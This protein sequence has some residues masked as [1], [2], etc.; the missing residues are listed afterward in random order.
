MH[1]ILLYVFVVIFIYIHYIFSPVND[2]RK[3][4]TVY[5]TTIPIH[6]INKS[7]SNKNKMNISFTE[8]PTITTSPSKRVRNPQRNA[9]QLLLLY[10]N[11][12]IHDNSTYK[13]P[14]VFL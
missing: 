7:T 11:Y 3:R 14:Y 4:G 13:Q 5:S 8:Y 1:D 6:V 12:I 9:N 10:P 2:L